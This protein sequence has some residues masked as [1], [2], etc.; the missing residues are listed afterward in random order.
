[1]STPGYFYTIAEINQAVGHFAA[2]GEHNPQAQAD[3]ALAALVEELAA[4]RRKD[5]ADTAK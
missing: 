4:A 5:T 3:P 1:M 2:E